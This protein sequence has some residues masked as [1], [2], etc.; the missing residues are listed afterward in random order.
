MIKIEFH[1]FFALF[2]EPNRQTLLAATEHR[3]YKSGAIIF[4]EGDPS[5]ALYLVLEGEIELRKH[6]KDGNIEILAR[7]SGD[8]C[9]G[10]MGVLDGCKRSAAAYTVTDTRLARIPRETMLAALKDEPSA[11][12]IKMFHSI[13]DR[14]RRTDNDYITEAFRTERFQQ[15]NELSNSLL[16]YFENP[17]TAITQTDTIAQTERMTAMLK[18]IAKFSSPKKSS[19]GGPPTFPTN[20]SSTA[21]TAVLRSSGVPPDRQT[22]TTKKL[23][24]DFAALNQPFLDKKQIELTITGGDE[25]TN[26]NSKQLLNALQN[27]INNSIEAEASKITISTYWQPST[28]EFTIQDNG[29]GVPKRIKN[30]LFA[31]FVT[32][33][34]QKAIGLGLAITKS[35]AEEHGGHIIYQPREK[36]G[37]TFILTI[38]I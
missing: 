37:S 36:Q 13:S 19:T 5:D 25:T 12:I 30:T 17:M 26:L 11:T 31:P 24:T 4:D 38:P 16:R 18:S 34:K 10:E 21:E 29:N 7:L 33:G 9:F 8:E 2:S 32:E 20:N 14:L 27:L 1:Q 22:F 6:T 23:L 3:I 35:I 28:I 15:V